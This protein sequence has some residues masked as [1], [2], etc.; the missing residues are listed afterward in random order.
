[1][2]SPQNTKAVS[3]NARTRIRLLLGL[4][5]VLLRRRQL[6]RWIRS[7]QRDYLLHAR[8]PWLCFEAIDYLANLS[9]SDRRVFEYGSGGSTLFWLG[10]GAHCVSV[11]HDPQWYCRMRAWLPGNASLDYRLVEPDRSAPGQ[12]ASDPADPD[13]YASSDE[14]YRGLTFRTYASQ[15][16]EFEDGSFDVILV[17]GRA[18][19][20]CIKHSVRKVKPGGIIVLDNAEREHYLLRAGE[21]LNAFACLSLSGAQPANRLLSAT[22]IYGKPA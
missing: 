13:A 17:D 10:H 16:D 19:P 2:P 9:L 4:M 8:Q 20:S 7:F 15:I 14:S 1:M 5:S 3:A 6:M 12:A 11:E 18:R 21:L 22:N